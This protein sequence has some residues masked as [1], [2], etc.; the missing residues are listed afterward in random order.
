[1][2]NLVVTHLGEDV[3][4]IDDLPERCSVTIYA[5]T[6]S[7]WPLDVVRPVRVVRLDGLRDADDA[8][9]HHILEAGP[10]ARDG[11]RTVFCPDRVDELSPGLPELLER[12][13]AWAPVQPLSWAACPIDAPAGLPADPDDPAH[14]ALWDTRDW[15]DGWPVEPVRFALRDLQPSGRPDPALLRIAARYRRRHGLARHASLAAHLLARAGL[16]ALAEDARRGDLG[17]HAPGGLFAVHGAGLREAARRLRPHATTLDRMLHDPDDRA[18]WSRLWLHVLGLPFVRIAPLGAPGPE[19]ADRPA[20]DLAQTEPAL[21]RA[22]AT[23]DATLARAP[24]R[25]AQPLRLPGLPLPEPAPLAV[26]A[27]QARTLADRAAHLF[28][29]GELDAAADTA[30]QALRIDPDDAGSR[31]SLAMALAALGR[32]DE[33]VPLFEHLM[34]VEGQQRALAQ[35]VRTDPRMTGCRNLPDTPTGISTTQG[36]EEG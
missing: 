10:A 1:M 15:I 18:L 31:F 12:S 6:A 3:R 17:V 4:W 20:Q 23:I 36:T 13:A 35:D 11:T 2:L 19:P 27:G 8:M 9:L 7:E 24:A 28:R 30:R 22:L 5:D 16:D 25:R 34:R 33:A 14:D 29:Q 26:R 21:A 32:H